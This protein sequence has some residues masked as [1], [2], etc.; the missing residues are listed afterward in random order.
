MGGLPSPRTNELI[1]PI[2]HM[3]AEN[4]GFIIGISFSRGLF[5]GTMLVLGGGMFSIYLLIN[6][7]QVG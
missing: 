6:L 3:E 7:K 5:S 2:A 4:D 1:D